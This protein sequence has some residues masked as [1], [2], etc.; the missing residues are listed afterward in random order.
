MNEYKPQAGAWARPLK[1]LDMMDDEWFQI[2]HWSELTTRAKYFVY[3]HQGEKIVAI[4]EA[5]GDELYITMLFESRL[6]DVVIFTEN[7]DYTLWWF[8]PCD[9]PQPPKGLE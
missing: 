3:Y 6:E 9:W 5:D 8:M 2:D 7:F 1:S 4:G